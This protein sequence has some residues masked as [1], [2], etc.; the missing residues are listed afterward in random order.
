MQM[1]NAIVVL[2]PLNAYKQKQRWKR[3]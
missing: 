3:Y 1:V 2:A